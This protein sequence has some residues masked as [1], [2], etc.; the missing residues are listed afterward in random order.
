MEARSVCL[1]SDDSA[2]QK[3]DGKPCFKKRPDQPFLRV[4]FSEPKIPLYH[5]LLHFL[6]LTPSHNS[7]RFVSL[8]GHNISQFHCFPHLPL[9]AAGL[10]VRP[11]AISPCCVWPRARFPFKPPIFFTI[12]PFF[13]TSSSR[14]FGRRADCQNGKKIGDGRVIPHS[15]FRFSSSA[16]ALSKRWE[17]CRL[18]CWGSA[19]SLVMARVSCPS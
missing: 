18:L 10:I 16:R 2:P 8:P 6:C 5:F 3:V 1:F 12:F 4:P 15:R 14:R 19:H 13:A 11:H 17:L 9:R 7:P